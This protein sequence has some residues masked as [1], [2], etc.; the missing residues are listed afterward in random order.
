M[1]CV[2]AA[3]ASPR[4]WR[5]ASESGGCGSVTTTSVS[6]AAG[7]TVDAAPAPPA[8]RSTSVQRRNAGA[9]A[10]R[11]SRRHRSPGYTSAAR[12]CGGIGRRARFRSVWGQPRGG[13][14]P[15]IRIG[16]GQAR[17]LRREVLDPRAAAPATKHFRPVA[18]KQGTRRRPADPMG[19][20][21][22]SIRP[23][24]AMCTATVPPNGLPTLEDACCVSARAALAAPTTATTIAAPTRATVMPRCFLLSAGNA[25]G[26]G[27]E[28]SFEGS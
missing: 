8:P 10:R 11:R 26:E 23:T 28:P 7:A 1:W 21:S 19:A 6:A 13:S 25:S 27:H 2:V 17:T 5:I 24:R 4:S 16:N 12:G 3:A 20:R 18:P 14:S 22:S 15:L 9:G